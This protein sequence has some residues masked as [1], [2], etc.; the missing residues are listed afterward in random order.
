MSRRHW[1]HQGSLTTLKSKC[2]LPWKVIKLDSQLRTAWVSERFTSSLLLERGVPGSTWLDWGLWT[3][4]WLSPIKVC[5]WS[6]ELLSG[7][8]PQGRVPCR[9]TQACL[10]RSLFSFPPRIHESVHRIT[11][12]SVL[13]VYVLREGNTCFKNKK[14]G[15]RSELRPRSLTNVGLTWVL[16]NQKLI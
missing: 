15:G 7:A 12:I 6:P 9:D 16:G 14:F 10:A 1:C 11:S 13:W 2:N 3:I 4:L 5:H 8:F